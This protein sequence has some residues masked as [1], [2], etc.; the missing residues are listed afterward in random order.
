IG[1]RTT[2]AVQI[3]TTIVKVLPL[4]ALSVAFFSNGSFANLR[5]FAPHGYGGLFPAISLIAWLFLGAESA[6]VPAE[7][8]KGAGLTI[9]PA[10]YTGY[11]LVVVV[12]LTLA[13]TINYGLPASAIARKASP[14]ADAAT[15]LL[16]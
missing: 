9:R 8:V 11:G 7:E 16:A 13:F 3:F 2:G 6:T 14:L 4:L 15:L 1:V 12:Y 10:A 5:P